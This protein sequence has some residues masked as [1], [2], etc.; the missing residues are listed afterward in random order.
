MVHQSASAASTAKP[1]GTHS[2]KPSSKPSGTPFGAFSGASIGASSA[3]LSGPVSAPQ[4]QPRVHLREIIDHGLCLILQLAGLATGL[5]MIAVAGFFGS[6]A[7]LTPVLL[8]LLAMEYG[9]VWRRLSPAPAGKLSDRRSRAT[10]GILAVLLANRLLLPLMLATIWLAKADQNFYYAALAVCVFHAASGPTA[11]RERGTR[12]ALVTGAPVML[13]ALLA[14]GAVMFAFAPGNGAGI[15]SGLAAG[16]FATQVLRRLNMELNQNPRTVSLRAVGEQIEREQR[17]SGERLSFLSM[18]DHELRTP[19]NGILGM[20]QLL[21]ST[22]L[23]PDQQSYARAAHQSGMRILELMR[24]VCDVT[25][26]TEGQLQLRKDSVNMSLL[27]GDVATNGAARAHDGKA[28]FKVHAGTGLPSLV[29][30]DKARLLQIV[31]IFLDNAF[32]FGC[33]G[34]GG[35]V[36]VLVDVDRLSP[37]AGRLRVRV[38]DD[39]PGIADARVPTLFS[40][41]NKADATTDMNGD[42]AGLGLPLAHRLARLM[43]G[44]V[45]VH[46]EPDLGTCASLTVP[47]VVEQWVSGENG[48]RPTRRFDTSAIAAA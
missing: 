1:S 38:I 19:L 10:R 11:I 34:G 7:L 45:T 25:A 42:G 41:F 17:A 6:A 26:L 30:A 36:L 2:A 20:T 32:Q 33:A 29:R 43:G 22:Q 48:E 37:D 23:T 46:S 39:G 40:L 47:L 4:A 9:A 14:L 12:L 24:D 35:I 18:I 27:V 8:W 28:L 16:V 5:C 15:V 21:E 31:E 13:M 44:D 3:G